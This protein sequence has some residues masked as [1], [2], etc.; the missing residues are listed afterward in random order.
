MVVARGTTAGDRI[1]KQ[2]RVVL[3]GV[4]KVEVRSVML[5]P[6]AEGGTQ[7][8]RVRKIELQSVVPNSWPE[9]FIN[10]RGNVLADCIDNSISEDSLASLIQMPGGC[11][12]QNLASI[13]LP[14]IATLYL[15]RTNS[16][17][18]VGVQRRAEALR[19]IRRGARE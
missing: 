11:V 5:S 4:Q 17:E 7:T 2:L 16:W 9:T 1:Q 10:V 13:T 14:L 3:E 6:S 15:D 8:V 12:E 19:Y 18:S